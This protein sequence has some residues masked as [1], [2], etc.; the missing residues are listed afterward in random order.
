[1]PSSLVIPSPAFRASRAAFTMLE[2]LMAL[3]IIALLAGVLISGS[4][5][6]LSSQAASVDEVFWKAVQT[7]RKTALKSGL[8]V[9]LTFADD[10]EKGKEFVVDDGTTKQEL[11]VPP[12]SA[13]TLEVSF[14]PPQK[15]GNSILVAGVA[16]ETQTL[17]PI[18][19]YADG[20]CTPFRLQVSRRGGA[21][22]LA[23]DPWTCAP[24]LT[25]PDPNAPP[26]S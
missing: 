14:L 18:I 24:I 26:V 10:K 25:P 13:D 6:A 21:H 22:A 3:A 4:S 23:I 16:V 20:T 11:L 19:F 8:E 2:L 15:G 17:S 9:H 7:A 12:A 5:Q 1:V